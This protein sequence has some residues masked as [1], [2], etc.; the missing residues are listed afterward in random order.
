VFRRSFNDDGGIV[1]QQEAPALGTGRPGKRRLETGTELVAQRRSSDQR[2]R[3]AIAQRF[4]Y[5]TT[6]S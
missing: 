6:N 3:A 1:R 5:A 4:R 2:S